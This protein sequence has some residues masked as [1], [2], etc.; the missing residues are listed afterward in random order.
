MLEGIDMFLLKDDP[1]KETMEGIFL[2]TLKGTDVKWTNE[3][4]DSDSEN[5]DGK[6]W[7][8][9]YHVTKEVLTISGYGIGPEMS[10][11][12][13]HLGLLIIGCVN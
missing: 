7:S 10:E 1:G 3:Y 9:V 5:R 13:R 2:Q 11:E 8:L 6:S 12:S 4:P